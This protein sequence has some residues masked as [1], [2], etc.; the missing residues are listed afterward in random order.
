[1]RRKR[2]KPFSMMTAAAMAALA[3]PSFGTVPVS[4]ATLLSADFETTND[5]FTGRGGAAVAWGS[6]QAYND[7]CSL[8]VSGR[9]ASWQGASRDVSSIL[10]AGQTYTISAYVFQ[11]S[12]EPVEMKFSMQYKDASGEVAYDAIALETA[13]DGTWTELS[14]SAYTI[15]EGASEMS[16]YMETTESLSDFYLDLV[17]VTGAPAVIKDGDAN[18]DLSVS[19]ADVVQ[20]TKFI[21]GETTSVEIGADFNKDQII[22]AFDLA[23]LKNYLI[24]PHTPSVSGDWDNYEETASP[25][26]LKV[27]EDAVYRIGNTQRIRDKIAKAQKGEPVTIAYIGGSITAGGSSSS[28]NNC[29][30]ALSHQYFAETFGTGNNVT[31]V[32]AGMA[33]TSSVVGN[34]RADNDILSKNPDVIFIEFAVNDQDGSR[35][36]KSYEALVKKCLDHPNAPAVIPITLCTK[37]YG[38]CQNWMSQ[39]AENYDLPLISGLNA[40]KNGITNGT[41]DW[42]RDYGSGDT[43]HPGNGGHKLIADSIAYYFRK[44]LRSENETGEYVMPSKSVFGAEYSTAKIITVDE[45]QNLNKGSWNSGTNNSSYSA[46]GFTFSKNGNTPLSF[47]VEGKGIM[48][49][50]QSNDNDTMGTANVTVNGKMNEVKSKLPWTWGGFDGDIAYYQNETG[51]L[52]VSI[53]MANPST[54]FVLYGIA[55]IS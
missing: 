38:S 22:D 13:P 18:G 31:Y 14:N 11:N 29:Y 28:P 34:L 16:I 55:V 42:D 3:A 46:N 49:L 41:L 25:Q 35:F 15:P 27:Y 4:A 48:L 21:L 50:F 2:L 30:A 17:T 33:G 6:D 36:Q 23:M 53:S 10:K 1:M 8:Y 52:D 40:V 24:T 43:I 39:I 12:G 7:T 44:A 51:K 32:N 45:M 20:L 54:T 5:T 37:S 26:M 9:T 47:T 19:A